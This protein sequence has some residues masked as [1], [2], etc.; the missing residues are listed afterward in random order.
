M[1]T[2]LIEVALPLDAINAAAIRE[3]E[4]F[5]RNHPRS[6]HVWWARRPLVACRAVLFASLVDDPSSDLTLSEAEVVAKRQELFTLIEDLVKWENSNNPAVLAR[7]RAAIMESTGGNPPPVLD[8]FCGGGSIPLEAHRLGLE[9]HGSDLNPVAVLIT[10]A[11][12]EIPP[13]FAGQAPVNPDAR[14]S[15]GGGSNWPG[16]TGLAADVRHYGAW[17]QDEAQRRIGHLYPKAKL[18]PEQGGGEATVIA[19]IWARTVRC[20]NPACGAE[21]PLVSSFWLSTKTG[22][23]AWIEPVVDHAGKSVQF[24]VRTGLGQPPAETV[25]RQGARCIVCESPVSFSFLR[26]EGKVGRMGQRLMAVV[27][28]GQR[29]RTYLAPSEQLEHVAAS[30]VS[31]WKPEGS[32]SHWPGRTNVVEYGMTTFADLFTPRQLV[33]LTTFS[34]LVGEARERARQDAL[35][36][37]S[38]DD[39]R[40]L[41][42]CGT[43]ATAYAD[44]VASYLSMAISRWS[45]L[46][47][48]IASWNNSNENV[49]A[50]FS[51]QAIPMVWDFVELSPF[52]SLGSPSDFFDASADRLQA[53]PIAVRRGSARQGSATNL[54]SGEGKSI[55]VTDPPYYDNIGY[56]DLSDFFYVLLR[57]SLNGIFPSLF[58]TLLT[59][60]S[61]E[62]VAK[63]YRFEGS[64][65]IAQQYFESGLRRSFDSILH[66]QNPDY[67]FALFYAYKQTE[68]ISAEDDNSQRDDSSTGWETML[69]GLIGSGFAVSGTW[70]MRTERGSR[71]IGLGSNAL[72]S[73]IV[74]ACRTRPGSAT[75]TTR[76]EFLRE[77]RRRLA[78]SLRT[79][80]QASIAPADLAQA[81]I[82]PGMAIYSAY[83]AVLEPSGERLRVRTALQLINQV[84]DEALSE[85]DSEYDRETGWAIDWFS[86]YGMTEAE[87]GVAET[88]ANARAVS[89]DGMRQAGIIRSGRGRVRI[90]PRAELPE[91]WNP[92]ADGRLTDWEVA[93][94]LIRALETGGRE[95]AGALRHQVGSRADVAK[96]LA[97]RLYTI[98][99]RK[100]WAQ[101]ALSYNGLVVEWPELVR[102]PAPSSGAYVQ[103]QRLA[104]D[105][106]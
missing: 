61:E 72:A 5:T 103:Q 15:I 22:K 24:E 83:A 2:K 59:P 99:E 105:G 85:Q 47:N 19:W 9:A 55:V 45:D 52:S 92:A 93:Q 18:P 66:H 43:G 58:G 106:G 97:Y 88:L 101:E 40:P 36:T 95:A 13:K 53:L 89:V 50:L 27:A 51:R 69:E 14:R 38:P 76:G 84:R 25:T 87:Y 96:D 73:S 21:M 44:A 90:I 11:L 7:A 67:P 80:Q 8:P 91:E 77:L 10:K 39:G 57:R 35:A 71:S 54:P 68:R 33:A 37:G 6:M 75:I 82:G 70:P 28:E 23:K 104:G 17:M 74:L 60:K 46:S 94:H 56:A 29:R 79:M 34:D 3:K 31:K 1:P 49:R 62:L 102:V 26:D 81:A 20:P 4:P 64:R 42:D 86:Q 65:R 32:I 30:A 48:S 78:S 98:C 16:A 12:I 41:H 100:G 63:P